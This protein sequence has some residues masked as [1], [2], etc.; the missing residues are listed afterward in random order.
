MATASFS[1]SVVGGEHAIREVILNVLTEQLT[2]KV[3][4]VIPNIKT[5]VGEVISQSILLSPEYPL[6]TSGDVW[7]EL[8]IRDPETKVAA[9]IEQMK[10]S[11]SVTHELKRT[12]NDFRGTIGVGLLP[13]D[14]RDLLSLPEASYISYG[15]GIVGG[16]VAVIPSEVTWLKWLLLDGGRTVVTE[17]AYDPVADSH[18]RTGFGLMKRSN[19]G[20]GMPLSV[21]GTAED[22]W[23]TKS[24]FRNI[25][26]IEDAIVRAINGAL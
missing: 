21:A 20:W 18:S 15:R 1:T 19:H 16:K 12:A 11:V 8:G 26:S 22:N 4:G 2:S 6:I 17:F 24:L 14:Y 23:L 3:N 7:H 9:I 5:A 10:A 13:A 25:K